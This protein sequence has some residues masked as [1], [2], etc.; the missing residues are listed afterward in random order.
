MQLPLG[1]L[2]GG[3]TECPGINSTNSINSM[4]EQ[5][6]KIDLNL[7]DIDVSLNFV[8]QFLGHHRLRKELATYR[9]VIQISAIGNRYYD[10]YCDI[11]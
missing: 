7:A 9:P 2:L 6:W 3:R 11:L 1:F 8:P 5:R 10:I 4:C